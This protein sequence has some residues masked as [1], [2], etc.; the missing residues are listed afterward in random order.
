MT[1]PTL[2]HKGQRFQFD[3]LTWTVVYCN[4]SRAHC[5]ATLPA[6]AVTVRRKGGQT[7]TFLASGR[8]T[9]DISPNS[10][11]EGLGP[12]PVSMS[13]DTAVDASRLCTCSGCGHAY[14]RVGKR[15]SLSRNNYCPA[16]GIRA[17]WRAAKLRYRAKA[18]A[19]AVTP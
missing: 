5:V 7:H 14:E 10:A 8:R 6:R 19:L 3:F 9:M 4:E 18:K 11:V 12:G 13:T 1:A 16:C 2:L 17:A 15:A